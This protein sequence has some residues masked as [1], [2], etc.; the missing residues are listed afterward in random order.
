MLRLLAAALL[1]FAAP[2]A[3]QKPDD[4][5]EHVDDFKGYDVYHDSA[6]LPKNRAQSAHN[7]ITER[8]VIEKR[9]GAV[10]VSTFPAAIESMI[11]F[12]S[13]GTRYLIAHSSNSIYYT[14]FAAS[15]IAITTM[16]AGAEVSFKVAFSKVVAVDGT[17]NAEWD[18]TTYLTQPAMPRCKAIEFAD[19]RIWCANISNESTSR[20][21]ISS[22]GGTAY[23]TVPVNPP[24]EPD[25]PNLFDVN[26]DDGEATI[27]IKK[28]PWG[29]YL[30]KEHSSYIVK[31]YNNE[32]YKL[33]T[34]DPA[35]GCT[36]NRSMQIV[37]GRLYWLAA[38]GVYSWDGS[39]PFQLESR[40]I[41]S[42]VRSARQAASQQD[43]W[44]MQSQADWE[45]GNLSASGPGAKMSATI[46]P[47][48]VTPSTWTATDTSA[49]D[50]V[51]G[52]LNN[53]STMS[54]PGFVTQTQDGAG[55]FTNAGFELSNKTTNWESNTWD[56]TATAIFGS[57]SWINDNANVPCGNDFVTIT[58]LDQNGGGLTSSTFTLVNGITNSDYTID[59]SSFSRTMVKYRLRMVNS[60]IGI[61][62]TALSVPFIKPRTI[63]TRIADGASGSFCQLR[64]DIDETLEKTSATFTSQI[65]NVGLSTPVFGYFAVGLSSSAIMRS[66]FTVQSSTANDGGGF[67]TALAQSV[68]HKVSAQARQYVRYLAHLSVD[69]ATNTPV[70]I[71]TVTMTAATTGYFVSPVRFIGV[72]ISSWG[73][74]DTNQTITGN[75]AINW[76]IRQTTYSLPAN[77]EAVT[78]SA[79]QA[80]ANIGSVLAVT[81]PTYA[82]WRSLL[83]SF[84]TATFAPSFNLVRVNW[85]TG[86]PSASVASGFVNHWYVL[87]VAISSSV[88]DT[89]FIQQ[90][91]REW[92]TMGGLFHGAL[93]SFNSE[94]YGGSAKTDGA[95]WRLFRDGVYNDAG[96]AIDA[97]WISSDFMFGDPVGRKV[98]DE[99]WIDA[100]PSSTTLLN[101]GFAVEK[102]SNY[103][104]QSLD[105]GLSTT[106][107]NRRVH[108]PTRFLNGKYY[109]LKLSNAQLDNYFRINGF[110][111]IG[112]KKGR[113]D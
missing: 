88:N 57:G 37:E 8:G 66:S 60:D 89:C 68:D 61:D 101:V 34:L 10:Q 23:W 82:Q 13:G 44:T 39:G 11:E 77:N 103:A 48:S 97:R 94:L 63:T 91:D 62:L 20:V 87:C 113:I 25:A 35:I 76:S 64:W 45:S 17:L 71:A 67:H 54:A 24:D 96:Q 51:L 59:L 53:I 36:D 15:P 52:S 80:N 106:S 90:R 110:T 33:R 92:V 14:N 75:A 18:G 46:L 27:C 4:L 74:F 70:H 1:A 111:L 85:D 99:I 40:D 19:G 28:T 108:M 7:V 79:I 47:G 107:I 12:V 83:T 30:G 43:S 42:D 93:T 95:A 3:A 16:T 104:T 109:R 22:V 21:R 26:R 73:S 31:G 86:S 105:L 100:Q 78:W 50:F 32:N 102:S 98:V 56:T 84:S 55:A 2:A 38:D 72:D 5:F 9:T 81:T 41:E 65:F 58:I 6:R 49:A 112:N 29:V 69:K